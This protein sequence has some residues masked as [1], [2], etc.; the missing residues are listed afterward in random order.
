MPYYVLVLLILFIITV[1]S[2]LYLTRQVGYYLYLNSAT[3][4]KQQKKQSP[5]NFL[6]VFAIAFGVSTLA[7]GTCINVVDYV[8]KPIRGADG[9]FSTALHI[10]KLVFSF[11]VTSAI[12]VFTFLK[13]KDK[14]FI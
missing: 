12:G 5:V 4:G 7:F 13:L 8:F 10:S 11:S 14:K 2:I 6:L 3:A 1:I 9:E